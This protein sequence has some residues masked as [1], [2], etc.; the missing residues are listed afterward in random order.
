MRPVGRTNERPHWTPSGADADAADADK[1]DTADDA[2]DDT[3]ADTA[4]FMLVFL[5]ML[6]L[7]FFFSERDGIGEVRR[8]R[9]GGE[10]D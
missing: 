6:M 4:D 2:A 8:H 3:D 1:A 9:H 7:T 5:L 10:G